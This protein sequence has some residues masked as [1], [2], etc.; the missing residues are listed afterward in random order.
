MTVPFVRSV[1]AKPDARVLS[2][3]WISI[4]VQWN[5]PEQAPLSADAVVFTELPPSPRT[6]WARPVLRR[7][8]APH[9]GLHKTESDETTKMTFMF[10]CLLNCLPSQFRGC[11]GNESMA[12]YMK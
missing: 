4:R 8:G 9:K 10:V 2:S 11:V 1:P 6:A 3:V 12:V 7:N 5:A